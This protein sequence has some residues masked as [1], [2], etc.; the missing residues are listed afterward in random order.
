MKRII[1]T[2]LA[3]AATAATA[4]SPKS[5]DVFSAD[6]IKHQFAQALLQANQKGSG[7]SVLADYGNHDMRVSTR[8]ANGGA[9]VH[10]HFAD[11]F[12]VASGYATLITG[13]TVVD[14]T[15]KANGETLGKSIQNGVSRKLG[16]GDFVHIP[17]G[18]P[19]QLLIPKGNVFNYLVVKVH[20]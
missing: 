10:A 13:G 5:V 3:F 8:T 2:L 15:T 19:H 4:Q 9:E 18:V 11:V 1:A 20:E 6:Q 7:G 14:P 12:Y 17:A 16:P